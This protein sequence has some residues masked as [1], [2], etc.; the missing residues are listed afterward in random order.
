MEV[1]QAIRYIKER[2]S[3]VDLARRYVDLR[4][5]GPRFVAPCPFHQETKPSFSVN[6]E[7]GFFYCFGCHASGD[8]FEFYA[9]MNGLDFRESLEQLA[10]EMGISIEYSHGGQ[11]RASREKG[12]DKRQILLMHEVAA[13]F[14][15]SCLQASAGGECREYMATRGLSREIIDYFGLGWAPR[16]WHALADV[17]RKRGFDLNL[18]AQAGLLS[19]SDRGVFDRFRGRLMFPIKNLSGQVIAFGG[20][21]INNAD[22]AKYINSAD[23]PIYHKK[24]HLYGLYQARRGITA[25]RRAIL[26]EGYMDVLA[27]WQYGFDNGAGVLGTSLTEEQV[28]RL[29]GFASV[30][31]LVF[32]GDKPGRK[33]ALRA[34]EMLLTRGLACQ[35]VILPPEDDIDSLLRSRGA[36]V[37]ERLQQTA[38]DGLGYCVETLK[39]MAPREAVE[40]AREFLGNI[41]IPELASPYATALARHL[42]MDEDSL[43]ETVATT[44]KSREKGNT[45]PRCDLRNTRDLQIMIYAVRYPERLDDLRDL[46]ADAALV[47][48]RARELW[49][50]LETWDPEEVYYHLDERQKKFWQEQRGP[51]AAPLDTGDFE[52]ACLRRELDGY[53]AAAQ[54]NSLSA[55]LAENAGKGDFEADLEYLRALQETLEKKNEQS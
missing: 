45:S 17:L 16:D 20:R 36:E 23:T 44:R 15:S 54:K 47:S 26:T 31:T 10:A 13:R 14:Y 46:G 42:N 29:S 24:E 52:L 9:K 4:Q 51:G 33:A 8:I 19:Q 34:C 35:V 25:K 18:A 6:P 37:F 32:D 28:R 48:S 27:L 49:T 38:P 11:T 40:W 43:R 41:A 30:I 53:F 12:P 7:K 55:A 3:I 5:N 1:S 22:E 50:L 21:I 39:E 2:L